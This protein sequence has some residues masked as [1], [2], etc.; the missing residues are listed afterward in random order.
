MRKKYFSPMFF[1]CLIVMSACTENKTGRSLFNGEDL[2][3]WNTQG[4]VKVENGIV[5]R[6]V[7]ILH[8]D[9]ERMRYNC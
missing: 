7:G 2:D 4:N 5:T 1:F 3:L 8:P 9:D 6:Q